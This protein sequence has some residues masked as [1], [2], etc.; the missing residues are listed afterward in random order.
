MTQVKKFIEASDHELVSQ[1]DVLKPGDWV[2][3]W[4]PNTPMN[5]SGFALFTPKNFDPDSCNGPLGGLVLAAV[6]FL[7]EHGEGN[8]AQEFA[9]ELVSRANE[10]SKNL[11]EQTKDQSSMVIKNRTLN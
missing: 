1:K 8:F 2:L 3:K 4:D 6:Y 5:T 7:M 11:T 9:Q 10:L